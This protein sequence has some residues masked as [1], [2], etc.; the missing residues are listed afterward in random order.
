[1]IPNSLIKQSLKVEQ[2]IESNIVISHGG[3]PRRVIPGKFIG[4]AQKVRVVN[5]RKDVQTPL[6][7][8]SSKLADQ[9]SLDQSSQ[10]IATTA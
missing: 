7:A 4:E 3:T 10:L 8:S 9:I 2:I 5:R 1:M 6:C